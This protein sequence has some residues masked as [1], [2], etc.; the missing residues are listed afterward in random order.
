MALAAIPIIAL[1]SNIL[2]T[3]RGTDA[4]V[5]NP[6]LAGIP[7]INFGAWMLL[8]LGIGSLFVQTDYLSGT[9]E[10]T[11]ISNIIQ[12]MTIW[13]IF[14]PLTLGAALQ[15]LP[16][17]S[18]RY[19]L[20]QNRARL[21]FWML[22]GGAVLGLILTLISDVTDLALSDALVE[23]PSSLSHTMRKAGS[24]IFYGTVLG[25]IF[26]STNMI[27][28]LYRGDTVKSQVRLSETT[29]APTSYPLTATTSIRKILAT[30]AV[31]D[32]EIVPTFESNETGKPTLL[33]NEEE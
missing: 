17:A 7:E 31:L 28:G 25:A 6:D 29:F 26:H 13:L 11:G 20:S 32:T 10:L 21:A 24:V 3:L 5:E 27:S 19:P 18:G 30:G 8:P 15:V 16:S 33:H 12:L 14:I 1:S 23:D 4:F 2:I 22:S 9:N